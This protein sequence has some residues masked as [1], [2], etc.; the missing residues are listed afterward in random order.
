MGR[1]RRPDMPGAVFHITARM[2][3]REPWLTPTL[4]S[5]VVDYMA[6]ATRY[7]DA[8]LLAYVIM[9]NHLHLVLR[10]GRRRLHRVMQ[11]LLRRTALLVQRSHGVE[12]HVFERRYGHRACLDPDYVRTAIVYVHLNPVR[13]R[14]VDDPCAYRWSSHAFYA[15]RA[16][17]PE[18]FKAVMSIDDVMRLFATVPEPCIDDLRAAYLMRVEWSIQRDQ[19]RGKQT[20]D[21]SFDHPL[22]PPP[23]P[24]GDL[25]WARHYSPL[26]RDGRDLVR[27]GSTGAAAARA[28]I[29][30]IARLTLIERAPEVPLDLV[31]SPSK[32]REAVAVRRVMIRRMSAAGHAGASIARYLRISD[33]AVSNVIRARDGS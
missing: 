25:C 22:L 9:P 11:P 7:S 21:P 23:T 16:S 32:G 3:G 10:Q 24:A 30:E 28:D 2:Q 8:R 4:R 14:L 6:A 1:K 29:A 31:R 19:S 13:A 18:R 27:D 17:L 20:D 15:G 5:R 12:G 33:Q 26:F